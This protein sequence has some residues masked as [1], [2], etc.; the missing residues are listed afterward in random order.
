MENK[1]KKGLKWEFVKATDF[2]PLKS[3]KRVF[4]EF[5]VITQY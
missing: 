1:N 2:G 5:G 3:R 4:E